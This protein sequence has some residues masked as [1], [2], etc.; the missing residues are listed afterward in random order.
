MTTQPLCGGCGCA[1]VRFEVTEPLLDAVYCHCTRCQKRTGTAFQAS[2]KAT[3][4]SVRVTA[5]ADALREWTPGGLAKTFCGLCG[6]HLFARVPGGGEIRAVRMSAFDS[7]TGVRPSAHQ[8]VAYAA[9]WS[10]I[11]D[12]GLPRFPERKPDW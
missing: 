1:V 11:P 3:P 2:A 8:F 7:D 12:D 4:G 6:A 5:G 10:A 9:A